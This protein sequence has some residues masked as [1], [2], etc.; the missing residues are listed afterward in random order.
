MLL[1]IFLLPVASID[2]QILFILLSFFKFC[3]LLFKL[4]QLVLCLLTLTFF[5]LQ[6]SFKLL[7]FLFIFLGFL[8]KHLFLSFE[9]IFALISCLIILALLFPDYLLVFLCFGCSYFL[10]LSLSLCLIYF[11][12]LKLFLQSLNLL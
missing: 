5:L 10:S 9:F 8:F 2:D 12:G 7:Y 3:I 4:I 11:S 1:V 6:Y